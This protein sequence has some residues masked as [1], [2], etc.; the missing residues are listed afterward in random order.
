M[1]LHHLDPA[2]LSEDSI[3]Y[4][5]MLWN[6]LA[7]EDRCKYCRIHLPIFFVISET[8]STIPSSF[9]QGNFSGHRNHSMRVVRFAEKS[10]GSFRSPT[11]TRL[12]CVVEEDSPQIRHEAMTQCSNRR[13][14]ECSGIVRLPPLDT[15]PKISRCRVGS[16]RQRLR[17]LS[18]RP[19]GPRECGQ[20]SSVYSG[21]YRATPPRWPGGG[22]T[23]RAERQR[24]QHAVAESEFAFTHSDNDLPRC[25]ASS[26]KTDYKIGKRT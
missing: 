22:P 13:G 5:L 1:A 10:A 19:R 2:Q 25:I 11:T 17:G 7:M 20:Y 9:S 6:W 21:K 26:C 3:I 12:C 18:R 14:S 23:V 15:I 8:R 16:R 24:I 4:T